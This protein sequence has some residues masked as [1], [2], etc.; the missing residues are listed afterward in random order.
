MIL[1]ASAQNKNWKRSGKIAAKITKDYN[2]YFNECGDYINKAMGTYY[3]LVSDYEDAISY[4]ESFL[5]VESNDLSSMGMLISSYIGQGRISDSA[6]FMDRYKMLL[7]SEADALYNSAE[8]LKDV[9]LIED[10]KPLEDRAQ[11]YS[12]Y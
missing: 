9:G 11:I 7:Q 1:E 3:Y 8:F 2:N 6:D 12:P 5:E 4:L 10:A